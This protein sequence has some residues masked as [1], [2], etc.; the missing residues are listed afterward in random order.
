MVE[1]AIFTVAAYRVMLDQAQ[2]ARDA[3]AAVADSGWEVYAA[4]LRLSS[5]PGR[6]TSRDPGRRL[7]GTIRLLLKFPFSAPGAPGYAV[8][9]KVVDDDIVTHFSHCPPQSF[10]RALIEAQGDRGELEAFY[11]SWCLYDWPGADIIAGD[12][13]TKQASL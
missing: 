3:R 6:L 4:M 5:L 10:V 13:R 12:G 1:L 2:D 7:R 11:Q 8:S 9:T